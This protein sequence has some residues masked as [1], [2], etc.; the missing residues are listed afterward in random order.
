VCSRAI[1]SVVAEEVL[2]DLAFIQD[3]SLEAAGF[4]ESLVTITG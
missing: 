1:V 2:E 3:G 4:T